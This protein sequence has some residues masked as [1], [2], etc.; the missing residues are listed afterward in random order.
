MGPWNPFNQFEESR[1]CVGHKRSIWNSPSRTQGGPTVPVSGHCVTAAVGALF[2]WGD[3]LRNGT[4]LGGALTIAGNNNNII[5][6]INVSGSNTK[7]ASQTTY[8]RG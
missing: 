8:L 6:I 5:I 1:V 3:T 7:H 4:Q 2:M